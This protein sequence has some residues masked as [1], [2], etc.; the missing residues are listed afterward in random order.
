MPLLSI[1][2]HTIV[3]DRKCTE[4]S[5][6]NA[7]HWCHWN[8]LNYIFWVETEDSLKCK[9]LQKI[10]DTIFNNCSMIVKWYRKSLTHI[11]NFNFFE[12][13][14]STNVL[15]NC[16]NATTILSCDLLSMWKFTRLLCKFSTNYSPHSYR[17]L[18]ITATGYQ[19]KKSQRQNSFLCSC[20]CSHTP[21]WTTSVRIFSSRDTI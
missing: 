3:V 13:S 20:S 14:E 11:A 16:L 15:K 18:T 6:K 2:H 12:S 5:V 10:V 17:I 19:K 1:V 21:Q 4:S 7:W 8:D 9:H